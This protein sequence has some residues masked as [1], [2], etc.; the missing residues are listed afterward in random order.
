[1]AHLVLPNKKE[2]DKWN[3]PPE[4]WNDVKMKVGKPNPWLTEGDLFTRQIVIEVHVGKHG[5]TVFRQFCDA[6]LVRMSLKEVRE[7]GAAMLENV[8]QNQK[9]WELD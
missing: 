3:R 9:K 6:P 2:V 1:M 5:K 4:S 8:Y 7:L